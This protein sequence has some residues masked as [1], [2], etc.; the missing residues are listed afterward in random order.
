MPS[1]I[2]ITAAGGVPRNSFRTLRNDEQTNRKREAGPF[3]GEGDF[4][5]KEKQ[6]GD[7]SQPQ[8]RQQ[9]SVSSRQG[10]RVAPI[11]QRNKSD[12]EQDEQQQAPLR[13]GEI[14]SKMPIG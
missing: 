3:E 13:P 6:H 11:N 7:C 8:A 9:H 14:L 12:R 10:P 1:V 4:A 2:T 5:Q